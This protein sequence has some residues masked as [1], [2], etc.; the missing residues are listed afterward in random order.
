MQGVWTLEKTFVEQSRM[1]RR[2]PEEYQGIPDVMMARMKIGVSIP[3]DLIAFADETAQERGVSR[4]E[5]LARLLEAER[6]RIQTAKYLDRY[7][8]DVVDDEA[9]WRQYQ[10]RRAAQEYRD[11]EW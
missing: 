2:E 3:E 5:L 10:R 8:W 6:I 11:D 1:I 4:S 9:R 7:G